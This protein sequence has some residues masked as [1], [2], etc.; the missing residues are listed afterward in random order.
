MHVSGG[1]ADT[2]KTTHKHAHTRAHAQ[3]KAD[4]ML[5]K[6]AKQR[7]KVDTESRKHRDEELK[8]R[9][10]TELCGSVAVHEGGRSVTGP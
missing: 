4:R 6:E 7:A 3:A 5:K 8:R 2:H 1:R 9:L 10:V